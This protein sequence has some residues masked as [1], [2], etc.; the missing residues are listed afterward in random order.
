M[1]PNYVEQTELISSTCSSV[2][3]KKDFVLNKKV[4]TSWFPLLSG[5]KQLSEG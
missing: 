1:D 3:F 4:G 5:T 2:L